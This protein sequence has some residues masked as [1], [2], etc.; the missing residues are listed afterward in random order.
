V[1]VSA[2]VVTVVGLIVLSLI[3]GSQG[4]L[5]ALPSSS[6]LVGVI[7]T[8]VVVA[9]AMIVPRVRTWLLGRLRP[10]VRQTWPRLAQVLSQPW[11]IVLGV[12]GNLLLTAAYVGAFDSTLRAFGQHMPLIDITVLFLL[13]NAVGALVP[14]PGGLGAVETALTVGL[15][16]AGL[17]QGI[18]ASVVVVYRLISYWARIPMGFFAMRFLQRRGEL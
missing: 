5:A 8:A 6:V 12:S 15:V 11:R 1:Q 3:T 4:T 9:I 18:A 16:S 14:T 10:L 2:V 7:V 13:G 17:P